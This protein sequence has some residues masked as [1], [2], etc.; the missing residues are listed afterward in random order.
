MQNKREKTIFVFIILAFF[1]LAT[2]VIILVVL[3]FFMRA[4]HPGPLDDVS[5]LSNSRKLIA[6]VAYAILVICLPIPDAF[7]EFLM[8]PLSFFSQ[9]L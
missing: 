1:S 2:A 4:R 3:L 5:K 6:I 7:I 8:N 9:F